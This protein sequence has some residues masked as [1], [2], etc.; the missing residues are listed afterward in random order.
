MTAFTDITECAR[1]K[2][3]FEFVDHLV[4]MVTRLSP[5]VELFKLA[6]GIMWYDKEKSWIFH[7][8]RIAEFEETG[9][10]KI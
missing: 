7:K 2:F 5:D 1:A 4:E 3:N 8:D 6:E 10:L 9:D